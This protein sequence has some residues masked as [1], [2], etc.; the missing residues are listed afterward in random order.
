MVVESCRRRLELER[1]FTIARRS[2]FFF[3]SLSLNDFFYVFV[4]FFF[5]VGHCVPSELYLCV[6]VKSSRLALTQKTKSPW[7]EIRSL[8]FPFVFFF[9]LFYFHIF[10]ISFTWMVRSGLKGVILLIT[11][12][13]PD[14]NGRDFTS[15][16]PSS[17]LFTFI[18]SFLFN[19]LF[20]LPL[21]YSF[22]SHP[23]VLFSYRYVRI[24]H[25]FMLN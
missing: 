20:F 23:W 4:F 12:I 18:D 1:S 3:P 11:T 6:P 5:L 13:R 8:H 19:S 10:I 15:T 22:F 7:I 25:L 24:L 2:Y 14:W 21:F 9:H 16:Y 17:C